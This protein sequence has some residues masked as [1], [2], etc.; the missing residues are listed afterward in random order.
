M[1]HIEYPFVYG[2][3][4]FVAFHHSEILTEALKYHDIVCIKSQNNSFMSFSYG[5]F[6][7]SFFN[8]TGIILIE[9]ALLF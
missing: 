4:L 7:I 6:L 1:V 5:K 9:F 2:F 3:F 8:E